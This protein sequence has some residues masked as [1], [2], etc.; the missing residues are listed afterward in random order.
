MVC[1]DTAVKVASGAA[2]SAP[3]PSADD[4]G[5]QMEEDDETLPGAAAPADP[6]AMES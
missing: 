2:A 5:N 1:R 3:V 6:D 4:L